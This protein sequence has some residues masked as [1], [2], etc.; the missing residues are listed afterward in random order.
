MQTSSMTPWRQRPHPPGGLAGR[1]L[2]SRVVTRNGDRKQSV[3]WF[4]LDLQLLLESSQSR[5]DASNTREGEG[6]E[7]WNEGPACE[8][9][10]LR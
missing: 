9:P 3:L 8:H 10:N 2:G 4:F 5:P 1:P 6:D 7:V